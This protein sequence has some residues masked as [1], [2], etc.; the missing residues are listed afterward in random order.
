MFDPTPD[1]QGVQRP[2]HV[3]I[4]LHHII[5]NYNSIKSHVGQA[6]VMA[7]LKANAYGHGVIEVAQTLESIEAD[8]FGVAYVEEGI[9]LRE[10]KIQTPILVLGG[11]I[12]SQIPLF[13]EN[14]LDI[15]ASSVDKLHA[16]EAVASTLGKRARVQLKIDTGMSR[17]G[18]RHDSADGLF[19][20]CLLCKHIEVVGV[21]SHFATADDPDDTFTRLQLERFC[22]VL[23]WFERNGLPT[24]TRHIANSAGLLRFPDS[25]LDMVRPGISLYGV[26]PSEEIPKTLPLLPAL[27]W[28]S[29]VVYF[30]VV[31]PHQPVSYGATWAPDQ[32]TRVVTLPLGYGDGYMRANSNRASV[33][34]R[35]QRYPIVGRVCMDQ[36]MVDIGWNE[37]YNGDEVVILGTQGDERITIESL[38][39]WSGTIPYEVLTAINARVPRVYFRS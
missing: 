8:Y 26:Y 36:L 24:P 30:K 1:E 21:F 19:E 18:V 6:K 4:R 32:L 2:T 38:A 27:S 22:D 12:G 15:T 34:I 14:N 13:L 17:I 10:A 23:G 33:L 16:I 37:A 28:R 7:I 39:K 3:E 5:A 29:R 35:G 9:A 20:A 25:H 31:H 11:I